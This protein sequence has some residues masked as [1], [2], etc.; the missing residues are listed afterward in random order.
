MVEKEPE[1]GGRCPVSVVATRGGEFA[2][3]NGIPV[4]PFQDGGCVDHEALGTV[5]ER[6]VAAGVDVI[7]ACGNTS[8][9]GSLTSA[10]AI[11]VA[12]S[13]IEA[14]GRCS[15]L[16]GIGGDVE[17]AIQEARAGVARGASGIMVHYPADVYVSD[18]GL[19][20]YYGRIVSAIEAPVVLYVRDRG[21]GG[22]V[23]EN[24]LRF[25]NVVAVKYAL[26]DLLGFA[27]F[28]REFGSDVVALCGLAEMWAPFFWLLGAKGFTSGLVNVEPGLSLGLWTALKSGDFKLALAYWEK[29]RPFEELRA[30][31]RSGLN[32]SVVKA[33]MLLRGLLSDGTV[34]PPITDLD[35]AELSEVKA[36]LSSWDAGA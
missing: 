23:L 20:E 9:Y 19:I 16:V 13:T 27:G 8:E 7:V 1:Q 33:A 4:T 5:V 22:R 2:G 26:P 29:I 17:T 36:V 6:M 25:E 30:R 32:V 35:E 10:E 28:V 24:V 21:L 34:R 11:A 14:A 15:S 18:A 31:H 12:G 3:V